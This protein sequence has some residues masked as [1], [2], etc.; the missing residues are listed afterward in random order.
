MQKICAQIPYKMI[1]DWCFSALRL[2]RYCTYYVVE[3]ENW[4]ICIPDRN[5]GGAIKVIS[6]LT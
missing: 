4:G 6:P 3:L 1:S 5:A 2:A